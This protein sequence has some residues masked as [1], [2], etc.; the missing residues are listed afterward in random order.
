VS[1]EQGTRGCLLEPTITQSG[2]NK[3]IVLAHQAIDAPYVYLHE[4]FDAKAE[5]RFRQVSVLRM[6]M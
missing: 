6:N 2:D 1:H 3:R 4:P 5:E